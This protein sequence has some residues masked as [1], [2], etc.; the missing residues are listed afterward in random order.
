MSN[1]SICMYHNVQMNLFKGNHFFRWRGVLR[2]EKE[3]SENLQEREA[4]QVHC[5]WSGLVWDRHLSSFT[6]SGNKNA[7]NPVP[8]LGSPLNTR[9]PPSLLSWQLCADSRWKHLLVFEFFQKQPP[10]RAVW[11]VMAAPAPDVRRPF[12]SSK[13]KGGG[14]GDACGLTPAS[15]SH[16][17]PPGPRCSW[18]GSPVL[19]S[20]GNTLRCQHFLRESPPSRHQALWGVVCGV[21]DCP[22]WGFFEF[23]SS[24]RKAVSLSRC[25][26]KMRPRLAPVR[27]C[28]CNLM[29]QS[30]GQLR[31]F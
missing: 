27:I 31:C 5:L 13:S 9:V 19:M 11:A 22:V 23:S 3:K 10:G 28:S 6:T 15:S 24:P 1:S 14:A 17:L 25:D 2:L 16:P 30:T 8:C 20:A 21:L 18:A 4:S 7:C 26:T 29:H 12:S